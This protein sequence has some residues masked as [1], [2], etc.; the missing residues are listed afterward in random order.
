[1][2]LVVLALIFI[3]VAFM[4]YS[5]FSWMGLLYVALIPIP[6]AL[7]SLHLR[8]QRAEQQN[9]KKTLSLWT[10]PIPYFS[11]F[12]IIIVVFHIVKN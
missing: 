4:A 12:F 3:F 5:A 7:V 1:M 6:I 10:S 11:L 8:K 2:K 9:D